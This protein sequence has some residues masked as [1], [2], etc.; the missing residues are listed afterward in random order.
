MCPKWFL[1]I[2]QFQRIK[3]RETSCPESHQCR[4]D[5]ESLLKEDEEMEEKENWKYLWKEKAT[6]RSNNA[7]N[8][9]QI[10]KK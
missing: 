5:W 8:K 6:G 4:G 3:R 2:P 10:G 9:S 7:T 1:G